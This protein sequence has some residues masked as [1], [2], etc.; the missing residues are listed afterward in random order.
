MRLRC[1][2]VE[3]SQATQLRP[4]ERITRIVAWMSDCTGQ[5]VWSDNPDP[6]L[7]EWGG[8]V[9]LDQRSCL[10]PRRERENMI[11]RSVPVSKAF[12]YNLCHRL[13]KVYPLRTVCRY[14]DDGDG[15]RV[16]WFDAQ[17]TIHY[18]GGD[19]RKLGTGHRHRDQARRRDPGDAIGAGGDARRPRR[20][21]RDCIE[22]GWLGPACP[23]R[24]IPEW[25]RDDVLAPK[26][27]GVSVGP[28]HGMTELDGMS[29][30]NWMRVACVGGHTVQNPRSRLTCVGP[31]LAR[32][33]PRFCAVVGA[34][35]TGKPASS[36][37]SG[38]KGRNV[39]GGFGVRCLGR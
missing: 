36:L 9:I 3:N 14:A 39:F 19:K 26:K 18:P 12:A 23:R 24:A 7:D 6:A 17:G 16:T 34:K 4:R 10:H 22:H 29:P 1:G 32:V 30:R 15:A 37:D 5:S 21:N 8:R 2:I 33:G 20:G 11:S 38:G 27:R 28:S 31:G 13:V 25:F 35:E